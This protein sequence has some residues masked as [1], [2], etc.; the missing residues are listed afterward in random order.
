MLKSSLVRED[1]LAHLGIR[2]AAVGDAYGSQGLVVHADRNRIQ[3]PQHSHAL[4]TMQ[5][6]HYLNSQCEPLRPL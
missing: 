2:L 6:A 3:P 5:S 1:L 4:L